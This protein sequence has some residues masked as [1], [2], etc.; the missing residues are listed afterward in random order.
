MA[1]RPG[2]ALLWH[3]ARWVAS[4]GELPCA[5]RGALGS[6]RGGMSPE[7]PVREPVK[8]NASPGERGLRFPQHLKMGV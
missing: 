8:I 6:Q 5:P 1:F 4:P 7:G 3:P 2:P